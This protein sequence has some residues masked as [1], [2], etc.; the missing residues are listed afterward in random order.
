MRVLLI[1]LIFIPLAAFPQK[2]KEKKKSKYDAYWEMEA[3]KEEY[4]KVFEKADN[5]FAQEQYLEAIEQYQSLFNIFPNDQQATARIKDI[6]II[7]ASA[8]Q[9]TPEEVKRT[10]IPIEKMELKQTVAISTTQNPSIKGEKLEVAEQ[11]M[12]VEEKEQPISTTNK[13]ET[14]IEKPTTPKPTASKPATTQVENPKQKEDFRKELATNYEDG[15]T[16]EIYTKANR[17]ITKR[18]IVKQGLGD[19]YLKV[20]H[21]WGGVYYF[22]NGEPI[23]KF[24]WEKETEVERP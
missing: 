16:E 22:K 8:K 9:I 19:E 1:T 3:K 6:E 21:A 11:K 7:L 17:T 12:A 20:Q 13:Q 4:Q 18:I 14:K 10:F 15:F 5:L 23:T 2:K 24:M